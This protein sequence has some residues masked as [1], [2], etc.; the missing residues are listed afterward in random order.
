MEYQR[1]TSLLGATSDNVPR[2]ITK[3]CIEVHD[4]SCNAKDRYNPSR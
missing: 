4:Q 2:F 1:I 3:K